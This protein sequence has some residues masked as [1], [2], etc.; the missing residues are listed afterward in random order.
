MAKR[1]SRKL[2]IIIMG[3]PG[4]GKGT[5]GELLAEKLNLYPFET[6]KIL[7]EKFLGA[8][9][10]SF[11]KVE[12]KK[13][14]LKNEKKLWETGKWCSPPFV[15]SL[16]IEKIRKLFEEG[17]DLL[18]SGSPKTVYEGEKIIPLLK[19]LYG[20]KNIQ[21]IFLATSAK[22]TIF[23][24]SHRRICELMRHSILYSKETVNLKKCPLDGSR[25]VTRGKLD[26]TE[27]IKVRLKEF[28]ERTLP[29]IKFFKEEGLKVKK[30][31]GSPPP[32]IVFK[33]ILKALI[34]GS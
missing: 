30:I 27:I 34:S 12:G 20:S 24:N 1:K 6:S 4:A 15:T 19:K 21:V 32:A 10:E 17:K 33:N 31:N 13:Y 9:K 5:Q 8:G 2:V 26:K 11:V 29:L 18:F 23:R 22:E 3:S 28:E 25:L 7:E 16:V 14:F